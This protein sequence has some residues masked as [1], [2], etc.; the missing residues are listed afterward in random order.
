MGYAAAD[1]RG[2]SKAQKIYDQ[3]LSQ[4]LN[5]SPLTISGLS[6][7]KY[8]Y[9]LIIIGGSVA[10]T[11]LY[12]RLNSDSTSNYRNYYMRG[13]G[14]SPSASVT[15]ATTGNYIPSAIKTGNPSLIKLRLTGSS[16]KERKLSSNI[17]S[18]SNVFVNDSYWK[19]T[20]D[21]V[22]SLTLFGVSITTSNIRVILYATL[23]EHSTSDWELIESHNLSSRNLNTTPLDFTGLDG[24]ID[25]EYK[26]TIT[27][28]NAGNNQLDLL[29]NLD[30]GA[31]YTIQ[32]LKNSGGTIGATNSTFS[33][34]TLMDDWIN[35]IN[36]DFRLR[37]ESGIKRLASWTCPNVIL[38]TGLIN[39][40]E[41]AGWWSN[42]VDNLTQ[43]RLL[44][45]ISGN[46]TTAIVNLYRKRPTSITSGDL[47][48]EVVEE[49]DVSGDFSA[50]H[51]FSGLKGDDVTM[52][53]V[54]WRSDWGSANDIRIQV[55]GDT[56]NNYTQQYLQ[57]QV[58]SPLA[59]S[60]LIDYIWI[61]AITGLN[62]SSISGKVILY[63][64]SGNERASLCNNNYGAT[65][66][67]VASWW[68]N[69][70]DE[71]VSL[72]VYALNSNSITSGKLILSRL[73]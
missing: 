59:A 46:N 30:S 70:V 7:D 10:N 33:K 8:D 55:N 5:S 36:V 47:P 41:G 52:Y 60:S 31:N 24:Y 18:D 1:L 2:M 17:A 34:M 14:S 13:T 19:N 73:R 40:S 69:T 11:D 61:T 66:S 57:G 54:E 4:N 27:G 49:V 51:T 15:N 6:G 21:E 48:W 39:Q 12:V 63:P 26:L 67:K 25:K 9:E 64:K 32:K 23:K 68:S 71:V 38:S 20:A 43:I 53:K 56:A 22:T 3:V 29:F 28:E 58:S 42:T 16:G 35:K 72:K 62:T 44:S 37:A 65:V 50:G 45:T